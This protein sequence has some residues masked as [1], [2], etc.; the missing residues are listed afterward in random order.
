MTIGNNVC[1]LFAAL[2]EKLNNNHQHHS[3]LQKLVV[4]PDVNGVS[5]PWLM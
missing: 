4:F 1:P 2:F 3:M 5:G